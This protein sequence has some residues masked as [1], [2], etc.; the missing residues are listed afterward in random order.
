MVWRKYYEDK[1]FECFTDGNRFFVP[2][3][4]PVELVLKLHEE[5][6]YEQMRADLLNTWRKQ[7]KFKGIV[8]F[9][10]EMLVVRAGSISAFR[11]V[12][13]ELFRFEY[14]SEEKLAKLDK[15]VDVD[16]IDR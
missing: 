9:N 5:S 7:Y 1:A 10:E 8:T 4:Y 11:V 12:N 2:N 15:I 6:Q 14:F 13:E 3:R 16:R